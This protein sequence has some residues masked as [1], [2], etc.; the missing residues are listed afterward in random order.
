[1][2]ELP[3]AFCPAVPVNSSLCLLSKSKACPGLRPEDPAS[4]QSALQPLP[5]THEDG[6]MGPGQGGP[7][8]TI[9]VAPRRGTWPE[10]CLEVILGGVRVG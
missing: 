9:T 2:M 4:Q 8:W 3:S 5:C 10:H 1:M 6:L 7:A